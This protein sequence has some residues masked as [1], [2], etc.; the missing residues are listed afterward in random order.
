M[1][2]CADA[3]VC[4]NK[5]KIPSCGVQVRRQLGNIYGSL[6]NGSISVVDSFRS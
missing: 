2:A 3:P 5:D 6:H 4:I 1:N